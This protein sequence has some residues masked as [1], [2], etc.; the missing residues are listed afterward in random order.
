MTAEYRMTRAIPFLSMALKDIPTRIYDSKL[1]AIEAVR[2]IFEN[3]RTLEYLPPKK[4]KVLPLIPRQVVAPVR[5]PT[6]TSKGGQENQMAIT[7][8]GIVQQKVL[9]IKKT[10]K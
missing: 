6:P 2:T 7:S 1:A 10:N 9:T 3:C 5:Y 4:P 8:K